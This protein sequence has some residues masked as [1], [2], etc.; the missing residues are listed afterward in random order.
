MMNYRDQ[1]TRR[2]TDLNHGEEDESEDEE[3]A[4][5]DPADDLSEDLDS[6][7]DDVEFIEYENHLT[8]QIWLPNEAKLYVIYNG[9]RFVNYND[10]QDLMNKQ[11]EDV[12]DSQSGSDSEEKD[13]EEVFQ[14]KN[15]RAH[16]EY[17]T[18][19]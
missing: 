9:R 6:S 1:R 14:I 16:S 13:E 17:M 3:S 5:S 10:E 18:T 12:S 11:E 2:F 4:A 19:K 8:K 15:H 7:D